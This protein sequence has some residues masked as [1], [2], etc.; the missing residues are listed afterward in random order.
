MAS[1]ATFHYKFEHRVL[2]Y[3]QSLFLQGLLQAVILQ[4]ILK[5][6]QSIITFVSTTA[7]GQREQEEDFNASGSSPVDLE[8]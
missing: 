7:S 3:M 6:L 8:V 4:V 1:L 2:L 5:S